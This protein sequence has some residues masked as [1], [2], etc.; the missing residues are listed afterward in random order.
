MLIGVRGLSPLWAVPSLG[1][2]SWVVQASRLTHLIAQHGVYTFN[3]S[4]QEAETGS[5]LS[6]RPAFAYTGFKTELQRSYL[7]KVKQKN[8]STH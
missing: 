4:T 7:K 3:P 8:A 2:W 5:G 6:S 1:R